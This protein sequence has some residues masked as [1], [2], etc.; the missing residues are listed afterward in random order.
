[1]STTRRV[2]GVSIHVNVTT[3][4]PTDIWTTT[5]V[6]HPMLSVGGTI[7]FACVETQTGEDGEEMDCQLLEF[8]EAIGT[9]DIPAL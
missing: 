1:V 8:E 2:S 3:I 4:L 9:V 7:D 5:P 6:D